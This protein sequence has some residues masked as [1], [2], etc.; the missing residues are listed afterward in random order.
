MSSGGDTRFRAGKS[1]NPNGRPKA[2]RPHNSAFDVLFDQTLTVTQGGRPRELTIEQALELQ[3][4]QAALGGSKMAIRKVLKMIEKRE[5]ALA[6]RSVKTGFKPVT[7]EFHH[8]ADNAKEALRILGIT[9]SDPSWGNANLRDKVALWAGQA[10][11][12]RS[13]SRNLTPIDVNNIGLFV[14]DAAKLKW[15]GGKPV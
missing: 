12:S 15:P 14:T 3:T 6:K 10:A 2:R 13:G 9:E 11:L 1:G 8:D 7:I 4:Y 5:I